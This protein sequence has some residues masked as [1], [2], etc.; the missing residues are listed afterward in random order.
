MNQS[1]ALM[2]ALLLGQPEKGDYFKVHVVDSET[3]RG[4][5]LVELETVNNVR[6]YT[7]SNGIVAF[8]EPGL[9]GR[10]VFFHVRSHGYE[11]PKDGFG[12]R[13]KRLKVVAG[14]A[15]TLHIKRLN[16]AER[17]Y[18]I[19][20]AGVYR[21]TVLVGED[22]PLAHALLNGRV[23]GSDSVVCAVFQ[24]KLY[25]FWGDTNRPSYPLGN[26][27]VPGATSL[28]P[29]QGGMDPDIG[30]DLAY[31]TDDRGFAKATCQMPGKGPTWING[32]VTVKDES[33]RERLF[34]KYVKVKPPLTIYE[35]GLV[36]FNDKTKQFE[37]RRRFDMSAP[38]FPAGHPFI[39]RDREVD[40]VYFGHQC[41]IIRVRATAESLSD[42]TC[43]EAYTYFKPGSRADKLMVDRDAQGRLRLQWR[44]DA[45]VPSEEIEDRL[46]K[47]GR[48]T[49]EERFFQLRDAETGKRVRVHSSSVAWSE[50]RKRYVM[51]ALES[52]GTSPLGEI[53]LSESEQPNGPWKYARKLVTH[54]KYSFYNPKQHSFFAKEKGRIIYFEATYTNMFSGNP[55]PTPRYNYNQIMYKVDLADRRLKRD[56]G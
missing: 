5:P 41:P 33:G 26:F 2:I 6:Y 43:Y 55:T 15:A 20:G 11:F 37:Q 25:W 3:R 32:L 50:Y 48:I 18:R 36:E 17:L 19:T 35:R 9:M 40:Y 53:W 52:F 28:L 16:I 22:P 29:C 39:H 42:L 47:E 24:G 1:F 21:D 12:Y 8:H 30:I 31:F 34:A 49:G 4:V 46:V 38:V 54:D 23:F 27:H 44:A 14:G 7:D 10:D 13:G 45:I 56:D 51:I